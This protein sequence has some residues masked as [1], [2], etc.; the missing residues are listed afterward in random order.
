MRTLPVTAITLALMLTLG[1]TT[2]CRRPTPIPDTPVTIE[3]LVQRMT[4]LDVFAER[5]LGESF[6][7]TS[8]DRSGG[9]M[10]WSV[11]K[12]TNPNGRITLLDVDGPGYVSRIWIASFYAE[13]WLF[14]FDGETEPRL[15][16][17][18]RELFGYED[19]FPFIPPLAGNSGG[20]K[21]CTIP[22]PFS[23][24]LRIEV[25]PKR[26]N[27]N[28]RNY[29][30]INYTLTDPSLPSESWPTALTPAQSNAVVAANAALDT[31]RQSIGAISSSLPDGTKT[32]EPGSN[33][34]LLVHSGPATVASLAIQI[35]DPIPG[36]QLKHELLRNLRLKAWWDNSSTPSIDVPIGDFFCNPFYTREYAA[37]A[38]ARLDNTFICR[39][40]MPFHKS[41]RIAVVND[42]KVPVKL[43]TNVTVAD[44]SP[45]PSSRYFHA[46]W[47]AS[48]TSGKPLTM[49]KVDGS[50]HYIGCFLTAIGQD[51]SWTILEGDEY[52][53]PDEGKQPG[54]F[55]TGL[56]DY[57]NGAYYY[58][59]LFDLPYHGLIEKGA[60]RTDQYRFHGLDAVDFEDSLTVGIE[61]GDRNHAKGYMSSVSYWYADR[62]HDCT[63]PANQAPLLKR[64]TDRF[65]LPGLMAMLFTLEREGLWSDAATRC[66]FFA[67]RYARYPW[68]DLLR[69]RAAAYREKTQGIEAV[70]PIYQAL[71]QS[72]YP[73]A[74]QQ[75]KDL[76]WLHENETHALLGSHMRGK[77]TL[78]LDGVEIAKGNS[79][80]KLDVRRLSIQPGNHTWEV[81]FTPTMQGSLISLCLRTK[82]GDITSKGEWEKLEQEPLPGGNPNRNYKGGSPLPNMTVWQFEPNAYVGMQSGNQTVSAWMFSHPRP[83]AK[84]IRLKQSWTLGP[85][86]AGS[87]T[88]SAAPERTE[89][90]LR[91]H[92]ID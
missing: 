49:C 12:Q 17:T 74:A 65:E 44:G 73:P 18:Q 20:G 60:M 55:G 50:G 24:H 22:I 87:G 61:F 4:D 77:Y 6:L 90:E 68:A 82:W 34:D 71:T 85:A 13:R 1:L 86:A 39:F 11:W 58:T 40:P 37:L 30:H 25:V 78:W 35:T 41:A 3:S 28:D 21:Y 2:S 33:T 66:D 46:N 79:R 38:L 29:Y 36:D 31:D 88:T 76:L 64:P 23:K 59:S 5:P 51:G 45:S 56:E 42:G 52:V 91:A 14:F 16:L 92:T 19:R 83:Y 54:Q 9:N 69:L 75:A 89:A 27:P 62:P 67:A 8:Y 43:R 70:R 47:A 80:A 15:D 84:R 32:V 63:L 26:L 7:L 72:P 48:A 57:F 10:D 81:D 53:L